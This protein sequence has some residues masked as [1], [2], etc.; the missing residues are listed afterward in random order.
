[1]KLL[2]HSLFTAS[3]LLGLASA[4]HAQTHLRITG[5]QAFRGAAHAAILHILDPGTFTYAY[6]GT[7]ISQANVAIFTGSVSGNPV[8]I[9]TDLIGSEGGIQVVSH[10]DAI[11]FLADNVP[12]SAGGTANATTTLA[13]SSIPDVAL[14]DSFQSSSFFFGTFKGKFYPTLNDQLIGIFA[15]VF[16]ASKSAP[17]G[18]TNITTQQ[19]QNLF[20]AGK[21]QLSVFTGNPADTAPVISTG[22]DTD[23]GVRLTALAELGLGSTSNV[24]QYQPS[25]SGNAIITTSGGAISKALVWPASTVQGIGVAAFNGG[26]SKGSQL[27]AALGNTSDTQTVYAANGTTVVGN[28]GFY[29][30]YLA[31]PDAETIAVPAGA[32]ELTYNGVPYSVQNVQQGRYTLWAYGHLD[33]QP[34]LSGVAKT[35][36]DAL[37][38]QLINV[39]APILLGSMAVGRSTDGAKV[40]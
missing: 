38:T 28:G 29:I 32:V 26:Y 14:T 8:I 12:Q 27:A 35:V 37:A 1:M 36:A 16:V 10:Q 31:T 30:S 18:L 2:K 22:R 4:S 24:K 34:S 5:A 3:I 39:D 25:T 17:N 15:E 9:K 23:A 20:T 13:D 21:V 19:A 11:G 6:Q 33:Y 40:Q 7:D